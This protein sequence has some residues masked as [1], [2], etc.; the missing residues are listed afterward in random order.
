MVATLVALILAGYDEDG[1]HGYL[2]ILRF[3]SK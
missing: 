3:I 1:K 2:S